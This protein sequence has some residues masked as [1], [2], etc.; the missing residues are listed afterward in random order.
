MQLEKYEQLDPRMTLQSESETMSSAVEEHV[1]TRLADTPMRDEPFPHLYVEEVF[2]RD[3][4]AE[5]LERLPPQDRYMRLE[6]AGTATA[7]SE[8]FVC[9]LAIAKP[10]PG[11]AGYEF[12]T[13][14]IEWIR[15]DSFAHRVLG[16]F[17]DVIAA[18][19][20]GDAELRLDV[21][22]RLVRDFSSYASPPQT[23]KPNKL[24]SLLFYLAADESLRDLGTSLY[25]PKDAA[26]RSDGGSPQRFED[27]SRV[28]TLPYMPNSL[29]AFVRGDT[30]F[31][32]VEPITRQ[33][34]RRDLLLYN[35]YLRTVER[36]AG[37]TV[38]A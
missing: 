19:L 11:H 31:H 26:L 9:P 24:V 4:Y 12:W 22:C 27:F 20:G 6:E 37:S 36:P 34:V 21:D 23:D 32:G 5:L 30:T 29:F 28:D 14:L 2:P 25:A 17:N 3:W 15:G 8:R 16:R 7:H 1:C 35:I 33:A 13:R 18:R 10:A 38:S